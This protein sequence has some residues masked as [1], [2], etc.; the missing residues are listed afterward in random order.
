MAGESQN[1]VLAIPCH[2]THKQHS[3]LWK[4]ACLC[5]I[6]QALPSAYKQANQQRCRMAGHVRSPAWLTGELRLV[7]SF[8]HTIEQHGTLHGTTN[9]YMRY[10]IKLCR[11]THGFLLPGFISRA[12]VSAGSQPASSGR[13]NRPGCPRRRRTYLAASAS[14]A[15]A[16]SAGSASAASSSGSP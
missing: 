7:L 11:S 12:Q 15:G 3:F 10:N 6:F 2:C 8:V 9:F 14:A 5:T 4:Y 1:Y 13:E 16:A